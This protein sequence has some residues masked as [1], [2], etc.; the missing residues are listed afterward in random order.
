[1]LKKFK[2]KQDKEVMKNITGGIILKG[3]GLIISFA[4]MPV[5]IKFFNNDEVLGLWFT[6]LSILTWV[7]TFDFGIGNGL[8]NHLVKPIEDKDTRSIKEYISS[9]YITLGFY[10]IASNNINSVALLL[11]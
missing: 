7:L 10:I 5:Y 6:I 3:L 8:R 4:S 9:A 1:M 2:S 11:N